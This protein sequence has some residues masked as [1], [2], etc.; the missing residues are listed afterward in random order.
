M[1]TLWWLIREWVAIVTA[2]L[3]PS[4]PIPLN[5]STRGHWETLVLHVQLPHRR[6]MNS[7]AVSVW[8]CCCFACRDRTGKTCTVWR[9]ASGDV[10]AAGAATERAHHERVEHREMLL[11]YVQPQTGHIM[12]RAWH[13]AAQQCQCAQLRLPICLLCTCTCTVCCV[14]G[15]AHVVVACLTWRMRQRG[16]SEGVAPQGPRVPSGIACGL[17]EGRRIFIIAIHARC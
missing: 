14:G 5:S 8:R 16:W 11:L 13:R 9:W 12:R 7:V 10:V 17:I 3:V 4:V 2:L 15:V 6:I 1:L